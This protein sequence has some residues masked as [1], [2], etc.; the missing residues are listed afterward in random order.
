ML[1]KKQ[2]QFWNLHQIPHK[3]IQSDFRFFL[4]FSF[5]CFQKYAFLTFD[6]QLK[7]LGL[8]EN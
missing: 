1:E 3:T 7:K 5:Q 6:L 8:N 4:N 2:R